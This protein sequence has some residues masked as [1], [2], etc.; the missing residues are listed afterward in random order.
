MRCAATVGLVIGA[1]SLSGCAM[2]QAH[3]VTTVASA[4]SDAAVSLYFGSRSSSLSREA[5][6]ALKAQV[7]NMEGCRVSNVDVTGLTDALGDPAANHVLAERRTETVTRVLARYGFSE[8]MF[9]PASVGEQGAL[10]AGGLVRPM[11]RRVDMTFHLKPK[12]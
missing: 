8:V 2:F 9:H 3:R 10:T 6:Q 12:V 5:R 1:L 11:R 4:C 7:R